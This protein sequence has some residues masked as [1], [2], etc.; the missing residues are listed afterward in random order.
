M[1]IAY[2]IAAVLG[3]ALIV[4]SLTHQHAGFDESRWYSFKDGEEV[5][6]QTGKMMFIFIASPTCPKCVEFKRFLAD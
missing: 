4:L 2:A 6:R 5:S 1:R 3:L